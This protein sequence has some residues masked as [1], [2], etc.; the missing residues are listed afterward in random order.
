MEF[1][2]EE[3]TMLMRTGGK[4]HITEAMELPNKENIR[5]Q[6]EKETFKFWGILDEDN[7]KQ[8]E[9][10]EKILKRRKRK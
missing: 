8:V 9:M 1:G 5:M 7:I 3:C 10:K 2:I 6:V 4:R